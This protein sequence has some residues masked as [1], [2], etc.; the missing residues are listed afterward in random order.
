MR[1]KKLKNSRC[2]VLVNSCDAYSDVWDLFFVALKESWEDFN[3]PIVL[4]TQAKEYQCDGVKVVNHKLKMN[5]RWGERFRDTLRKID[6]PYVLPFLDD[7]VINER[8]NPNGLIEQVLDWMDENDNID[9]FYLHK[10]P[11]VKNVETEFKKFGLL[12][13]KCEYKLTTQIAI[14]R[15][16]SLYH[17]IKDFESPWEWEM[18]AT[19]KAWKSNK[20]YYAL[21][22]ESDEPFNIVYGGVIWRGLWTKETIDIARKYNVDIDF[23]KRGFIDESNPRK[24]MEFYSIREHFPKDIFSVKFWQ[25][26]AV[27]LRQVIREIRCGI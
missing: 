27:R 25:T 9:V 1:Y 7:F 6:T 19:K 2:T 14:W 11:Y 16:D 5:D 23:L 10:H 8:T 22:D 21:L 17:L 12:P 20:K 4:N 26:L 18:Y 15:K 3:Y 13:Q 24:E